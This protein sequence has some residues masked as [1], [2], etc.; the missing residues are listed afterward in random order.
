MPV[1]L[2]VAAILILHSFTA[3]AHQTRAT[4]PVRET[5]FYTDGGLRLQAYLYKPKG[6]GPFPMLVYN[7]GSRR[8]DE[9]VEYPAAYIAR[10]FVPR[11]YVVLVPERRGYGKSEGV[12]FSQ[13][14]GEDRGR[15]FVARVRLETKDVLAA[16]NYVLKTRSF[17]DPRR[18]AIMGYSFGGM[19]TAFAAAENPRFAAAIVQAPGAGNWDHSAELRDA[20]TSTAERIQ[21]PTFCAVAENDQTTESTRAICAAVQSNG[22][23]A[24]L[25]IYPPF[26][27]RQRRTGAPGHALFTPDGVAIWTKDVVDFLARALPPPSI[28]R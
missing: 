21:V 1:R 17:V 9:R 26:T 3:F 11:G 14:L 16:T 27:P 2:G 23:P 28:T 15:R 12:T 8:G 5:F 19:V 25:K 18:V 13:E 22:T 4:D 6:A 10:I 20:L 7:H 24:E